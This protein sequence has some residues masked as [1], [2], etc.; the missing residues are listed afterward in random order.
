MLLK[1]D[2][3]PRTP[4]GTPSWDPHVG[5]PRGTLPWDPPVGPPRGTP[6]KSAWVTYRMLPPK[7]LEGLVSK[8]AVILMKVI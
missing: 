8:Q 3:G 5:P 1:W 6:C 2:P 7:L 4:S